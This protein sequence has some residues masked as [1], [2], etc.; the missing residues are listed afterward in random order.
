MQQS[1]YDAMRLKG[2]TSERRYNFKIHNILRHLELP[3][4]ITHHAPRIDPVLGAK[5]HAP[6]T[7]P[8]SSSSG[9][10]D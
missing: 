10:A 6:P 9:S 1:R 8:S 2:D 5:R 7:R 3:S 4:H